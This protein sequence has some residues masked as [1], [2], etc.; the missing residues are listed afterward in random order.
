MT[1]DLGLDVSFDNKSVT[2]I[3]GH[4]LTEINVRVS[5]LSCS[6]ME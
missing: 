5:Y 1:L 4:I 2:I 3:G 6:M